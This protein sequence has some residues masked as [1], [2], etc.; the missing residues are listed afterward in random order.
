[1]GALGCLALSAKP[2]AKWPAYRVYSGPRGRGLSSHASSGT[3]IKKATK[4]KIARP[5]E[6]ILG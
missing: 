2:A 5:A 1:V 3:G 6:V 4:M